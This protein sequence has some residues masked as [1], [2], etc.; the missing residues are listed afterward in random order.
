MGNYK[1]Y[2]VGKELFSSEEQGHFSPVFVTVNRTNN[3]LQ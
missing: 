2:N 1:L 3:L